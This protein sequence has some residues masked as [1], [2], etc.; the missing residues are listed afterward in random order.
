VA[1]AV[2][3][4]KLNAPFF[5]AILSLSSGFFQTPPDLVVKFQPIDIVGFIL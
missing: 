5:Q 4:A 1:D 2:I 3:E